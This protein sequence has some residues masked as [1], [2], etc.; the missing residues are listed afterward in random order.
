MKARLLLDCGATSPI[1]REEFVRDQQIL[2]K[3]R[4]KPISIWNASQQPITGAGRYYTQPIGLEIGN[5]SEVLVWEIGGI[6][7]SIDGYLPIA[8]LQKHNPDVNWQSGQVK[9]RSS[10]CIENCLPKQVNVQMVDAVQLLKEVQEEPDAFIATLEWRTED[11]LD[12]LD[13]L[14]SQY[15]QWASIF[16]REQTSQLPAHTKFDHRIKLVE[17]AEA[18]WGPL[19]GMSEQE[20]KGLREWLDKQV[21]AGKIVKSNS[22]AGAPILLVGKPDGSFRLCVDY[23]ALNK[24][25]VKNRYP[26]PLMTELRER[27]NKA[28]VFSKLDL[29]NGYHLVRMAEEDEEKTAFRTRFGLYYWRMMP[30]SLCNAPATFQSMMDSIL[31]DLLDNGVI[32]YLDDILV[33]SDRIDN[34]IPLV[35]E[36]LSRLDKAGLGVNLKKI[37]SI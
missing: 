31:H 23:R 2:T 6:E 34:H 29:K 35:Q 18:P 28:R 21:A 10:Y 33:Y 20:L 19:Y 3:Q 27:L 26:L 11:G 1:L 4:T 22:S 12:I 37:P 32:V 25:T 17:G 15:H 5:H 14:P 9:W 16:S 13:I 7:E 36:V 8:W 24:V 30:F